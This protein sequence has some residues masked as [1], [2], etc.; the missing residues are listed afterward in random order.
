[1]DAFVSHNYSQG[2]IT[3]PTTQAGT[4]S[5]SVFVMDSFVDQMYQRR[6]NKQDREDLVSSR[7]DLQESC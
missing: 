6:R 3:A 5:V 4:P 7:D 2:M 1:M